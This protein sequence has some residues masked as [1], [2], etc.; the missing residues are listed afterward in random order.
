VDD[1]DTL[2]L[3]GGVSGTGG[4]T[5]NGTGSLVLSGSN[6]YTGATVVNAGTLDASNANSLGNTTGVTVNG[7]SLLVGADDAINGQSITLNKAISG[8][9]TAAQAALAFDTA[10]SNTSGTAGTLTLS[11]DSII[12]LGTGGV[13]VHFSSI[14]NLND[15]ILHIFNWE[16]DT[17]WSGSPGGG[18]DQFY[19]DESLDAT[20]LGNL[21]F[22]SSTTQS[23]FL[24]SGFQIIGGDFNNEV[25]AVPEP[26]T[27]ATV[28]IILLGLGCHGFGRIRIFQRAFSSKQKFPRGSSVAKAV[29]VLMGMGSRRHFFPVRQDN[30][31]PEPEA[32]AGSPGK[33]F[34][35]GV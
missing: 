19:V 34:S 5:K 15:Y 6:S 2:T 29:A 3:S 17:V 35:K 25:I 20:R 12:D 24:S 31:T 10:Y 1:G 11:Q 30:F 14:A 23:S 21:R 28:L 4:V 27:L 8:S 26:E 13:V 16:G 18:K 33:N 22:Y 32:V 9:A 7:G